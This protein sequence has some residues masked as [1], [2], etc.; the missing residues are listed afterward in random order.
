MLKLA[1]HPH[2]SRPSEV[3]VAVETCV[4][5]LRKVLRALKPDGIAVTVEFVP[6]QDRLTPM[7]RDTFALAVLVL[8]TEGDAC[9]Y[10]ARG[11]VLARRVLAK[12]AAG[13]RAE[14]AARGN[15][16]EVTAQVS[17][18]RAA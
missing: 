12:H 10:A 14:R 11:N 17:G 8:T 9:T 16:P 6:S 7:F 5:F 1:R 13:A 4:A 15:L 3:S 2:Q 18:L